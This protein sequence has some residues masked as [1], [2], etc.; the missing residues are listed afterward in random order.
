M[1]K[2]IKYIL[3][4]IVI[5]LLGVVIYTQEGTKNRDDI[6]YTNSSYRYTVSFPPEFEIIEYNPEN[7]VVGNIDGENV[8]GV[9]E[10]RVV[11]V[12][13]A[14]TE[15]F[16][17]ASIRELLKLCALDSETESF[18]C[19]GVYSV[20]PFATNEEFSGTEIYLNG[21]RKN[22]ATGNTEGVIKGP[23]YI[24]AT[25]AGD[26]ATRVVVAHAP[27]S[28]AKEEV[29][30]KIIEEIARSLTFE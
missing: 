28:Q 24:F 1:D 6:D 11:N 16:Y 8:S 7:V 2:P 29:R 4:I 22:L 14:A 21:V 5:I 12:E 19:S 9:A 20:K 26:T 18:S 25:G 23:F 27:L 15:T 17:Q 10:L 30:P 13:S 3:A